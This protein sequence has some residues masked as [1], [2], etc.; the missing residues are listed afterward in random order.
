MFIIPRV[1]ICMGLFDKL[2]F[3]QKQPEK[4]TGSYTL[5]D[6][7]AWVGQ[8]LGLVDS[9][10]IAGVTVTEQ[11]ALSLS[12]LWRGARVISESVSCLPKKLYERAER[13]RK[14]AN[15]HPA[16]TLLHDEWNSEMSALDGVQLVQWWATI[17]GTG[18]VEIVRDGSGR[19]VELWPIPP[20]TC[21]AKRENGKQVFECSSE[22]GT[23]DIPHE[24]VL[25]IRGPSKDGSVGYRLVQ[26]ARESFG[27]S[28][29]ADRYGSAVFG[30]MCRVGG[31]LKTQGQLSEQARENLRQS[32]KTMYQGVDKSGAIAVLEDGLEFQPFTLNNQAGQ[33]QE[34]RQHQIHEICRWLGIDPIF[35]Y[36][37]GTNPGGVAEQQTRNFLQF[38]LNPWLCRW[39][40]EVNRKCL[41]PSE[42]STHYFEF[43]REA[44]IQMDAKTQH[45]IW[46]IGV[47]GGWYDANEDIRPWLNLDARKKADVQV[48]A[49]EPQ[50]EPQEQDVPVETEQEIQT[51]PTKTLNGAQVASGLAILQ[52]VAQNQLPRDSG[53]GALQV[54]LNLNAEQAEQLMGSIGKGFTPATPQATPQ[55]IT[56]TEDEGED[57]A[58]A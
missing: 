29:A 55:P 58:D 10:S 40:S 38:T 50:A 23:V 31:V 42:R 2:K 41:L 15:N 8:S 49:S 5:S 27:F 21:K 39:E 14:E 28:L 53:I 33:Y 57:N 22:N 25:V 34:T 16:W 51:D 4:R 18:Y 44:V 24:D 46:K 3:W 37:F 43:V 56:Q 13:G 47:D 11:T 7:S 36:A 6:I 35:V 12:T 54:L 20:W 52:A 26:V 1:H 32:W 17:W 45:E 19:A 48:D 30:N 9:P